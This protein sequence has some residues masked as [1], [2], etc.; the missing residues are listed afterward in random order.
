MGPPDGESGG[1]GGD[2]ILTTNASLYSFEFKRF[3]FIAGDGNRGW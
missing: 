3:H 1:D 2:V